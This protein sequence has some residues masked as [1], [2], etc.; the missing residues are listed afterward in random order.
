MA[1]AP[2]ALVTLTNS[3]W[4]VLVNRLTR[5][6]IPP[7]LRIEALLGGIWAHSPRAP[8]TLIRTYRKTFYISQSSLVKWKLSLF[9]PQQATIDT[10]TSLT[11]TIVRRDY[12]VSRHYDEYIVTWLLFVLLSFRSSWAFINST[13]PAPYFS[14]TH[15]ECFTYFS[16]SRS[17]DAK[18]W[19]FKIR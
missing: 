4:L 19:H 10:P 15:K 2:T 18:R 6:E 7:A 17:S 3:D 12:D 9:S 11:I 13:R 1:H 14:K 8:T 16:F 5:G